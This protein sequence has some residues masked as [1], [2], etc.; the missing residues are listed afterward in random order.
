M[1]GFISFLTFAVGMAL[2]ANAYS[3]AIRDIGINVNL[4]HDGSADITERWDVRVTDGTEW[5]LVKNNL[6][7]ISIEGLEVSDENGLQFENVGAWDTDRSRQ[8]KRG[9]CGI[10]RTREGNELCWGIGDYGDHIFT[11]RYRM[12][13]AVKSLD[14][15]DMLHMQL[16][17]PGLSSRPEN[18]RVSISAEGTPL[19]T[20]NT[21]I[22][23]FGFIGESSFEDGHVIYRSTEQF[24]RNSS[25]IVLLRFG[26][27]IFGSGSRQAR[28]FDEVLDMALDGSDYSRAGDDDEDIF[29]I[30]PWAFMALAVFCGASVLSI[31]A[32][33]KNILGV[34]DSEIV[35]CRDLPFNGNLEESEYTLN[36]LGEDRKKAS[37]ASALILKMI[38]EGVLSVSKDARG[39]VEI[40]FSDKGR[41][42]LDDISAGLFDMMYEAGGKDRILQDREFSRWS[43]S[44]EKKISAWVKLCERKGKNSLLQD[45][46]MKGSS[47]YTP[48]G[49][50]QARKLLGFKKF[51]KEATLV[52]EREAAEVVLWRDYM[53]FGALYGIAGEVARQLKDID[54]NA[55]EETFGYDYDTLDS[56][57]LRSYML[58]HAITT[59]H[60][61]HSASSGLGGGTSFGGGGGFS[62]G[63]FGGGSR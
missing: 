43:S 19:D 54:P 17:S 4:R 38:Y 14:D 30:L 16:V 60:L 59:G 63:G 1:R 25:V 48:Q 18:V 32:R 49:Q 45:G 5:Y 34:R 50:E 44:H 2:T 29:P 33:R 41:D 31:K 62:G 15:Y 6:G 22:W 58:S 21:R 23:G 3:Q 46:F 26:K 47:K 55:F 37:I 13:N 10:V 9:K 35:W 52:N 39:K 40:S 42:G 20:A 57:I 24:G 28:S 56:V 8:A 11:V 27:G 51:L 7:D 53:V 61:S 36:Q 12:T